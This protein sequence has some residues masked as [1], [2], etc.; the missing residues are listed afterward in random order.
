MNLIAPLVIVGAV[1][2]SLGFL[3]GK[4]ERP[5]TIT[6]ISAPQTQSVAPQATQSIAPP[7]KTAKDYTL[8]LL[9]KC[10]EMREDLL[11]M[12]STYKGKEGIGNAFAWQHHGN[13]WID[14]AKSLEEWRVKAGSEHPLCSQV[15]SLISSL[16]F[17]GGRA[18]KGQ[19]DYNMNSLSHY[20]GIIES[21]VSTL[22]ALARSH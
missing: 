15:D 22:M 7:A 19:P 6:V 18:E 8:E 2:F 20:G 14:A 12:I 11:N 1:S 9:V 5:K 16:Q 4:N 3:V 21:R 17:C 10:S 13:K